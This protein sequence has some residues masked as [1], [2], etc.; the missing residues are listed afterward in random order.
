MKNL[1]EM[2]KLYEKYE[3]LCKF[4][5]FLTITIIGQFRAFQNTI[6]NQ[7]LSIGILVIIDYYPKW[8]NVNFS[9]PRKIFE[10][11]D[12]PNLQ[13]FNFFRK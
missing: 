6:E 7:N 1:N 4:F 10:V 5:F 13:K 3:L 11:F 2:K 9:L 12:F 8:V